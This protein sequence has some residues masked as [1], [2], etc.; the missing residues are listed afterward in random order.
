LKWRGPQFLHERFRA[1]GLSFQ[2]VELRKEDARGDPLEIG[3]RRAVGCELLER[4]A[5]HPASA[6]QLVEPRL[7]HPGHSDEVG[8]PGGFRFPLRIIQN[9]LG[10]IELGERRVDIGPFQIR[11][12][13]ARVGLRKRILER[14]VHLHRRIFVIA[15][16]AEMRGNPRIGPEQVGDLDRK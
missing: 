14:P 9:V 3:R 15:R 10:V 13:D 8:P 5:G 7:A 16:L 2:P 12:D 6:G 11:A 1:V 4:P